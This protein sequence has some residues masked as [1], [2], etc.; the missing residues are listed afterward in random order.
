MAVTDFA[1]SEVAIVGGFVAWLFTLAG[2]IVLGHTDLV[3]SQQ[4]TTLSSFLVPIIAAAV[5]SGITF[6]VRKYVT[7]VFKAVEKDV[8]KLGLP[9]ETIDKIVAFVEQEVLAEAQ[10]KVPQVI[11]NQVARAQSA[12]K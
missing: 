8:T 1:K 10:K 5:I 9:Q 4:W 7:P 12:S 11:T 3:T 6:V 2:T